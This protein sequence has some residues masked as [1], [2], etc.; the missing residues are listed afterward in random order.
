MIRQPPRSTPLYS[1]AASDVYKRQLWNTWCH[2]ISEQTGLIDA[3]PGSFFGG[4][5]QAAV[6]RMGGLGATPLKRMGWAAKA[7]SSVMA[8]FLVIATAVPSWTVAGAI[9]PI[10]PCRCSWL[11][12][13][14]NRRQ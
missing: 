9:K 5:I 2:E 4:L 8:R 14:K 7:A 10:P 3:G 13:W 11:Y 1:S 6:G 12:H